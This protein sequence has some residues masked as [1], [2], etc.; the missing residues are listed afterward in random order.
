MSQIAT[1]T[2]ALALA[3]PPRRRATLT[4]ACLT[5]EQRGETLAGPSREA[6]ARR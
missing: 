5:R 1:A 6:E 4:Y 3:P 2:P